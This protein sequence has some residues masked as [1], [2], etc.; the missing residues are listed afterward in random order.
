MEIGKANHTISW[1]V[2]EQIT[3]TKDS[4]RHREG[5]N[6][7]HDLGRKILDEIQTEGDNEKSSNIYVGQWD[8]IKEKIVLDLMEKSQEDNLLEMEV[9]RCK[10]KRSCNVARGLESMMPHG[11]SPR[12]VEAVSRVVGT[13]VHSSPNI[14]VD[15]DL[16]N[17]SPPKWKRRKRDSAT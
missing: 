13:H 16:E 6:Q 5:K 4:R 8:A 9:S 12:H 3:T 14:Q 17:L 10:V 1:E 11:R 2:I 15:P 7:G